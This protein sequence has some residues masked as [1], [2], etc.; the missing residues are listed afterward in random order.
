MTR[1]L[2]LLAL[3]VIAVPAAAFAEGGALAGQSGI[4]AIAAGLAIGLAAAGGAL[5]QGKAISASLD[6]IGRNPAAAGKLLTP[7]L[8]GLALVESLV[9]LAFVIAYLLYSQIGA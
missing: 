5:G 3:A 4:I 1:Y 9:I 6:S 2:S 7:M 8:L